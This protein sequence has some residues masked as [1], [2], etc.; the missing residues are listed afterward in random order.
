MTIQCTGSFSG[1]EIP[2][3]NR[4]SVVRRCDPSSV[5]ADCGSTTR[6]WDAK[7]MSN[8]AKVPS[9]E[10]DDPVTGRSVQVAIRME[11]QSV[12]VIAVRSVRFEKGAD[13]RMV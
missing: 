11:R 5:G 1:R 2:K 4:V 6:T 10:F 9:P 13:I 3:M 12:N 7:Q 8:P